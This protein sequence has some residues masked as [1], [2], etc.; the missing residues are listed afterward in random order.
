MRGG[1]GCGS[2]P[3][4]ALLRHPAQRGEKFFTS[5]VLQLKQVA[6]LAD[7]FQGLAERTAEGTVS[8]K[9]KTDF[10]RQSKLRN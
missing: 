2:V 3:E 7:G 4:L 8:A 9:P 5:G 1:C 10:P 6:H